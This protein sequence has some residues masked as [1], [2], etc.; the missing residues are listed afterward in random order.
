MI[1]VD[2]LLG[3]LDMIVLKTLGPDRGTGFASVS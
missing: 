3:T 1:N 2:T